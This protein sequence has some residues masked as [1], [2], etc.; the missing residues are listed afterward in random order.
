MNVPTTIRTGLLAGVLVLAA[1]CA[2]T[3]AT[4]PG[5]T[6]A[7]PGASPAQAGGQATPADQQ[8]GAGQG[9]QDPCGLATVEEVSSALGS[10]AVTADADVDGPTAPC[11]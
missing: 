4:S 8:L 9:V 6:S 3:P 2:G 7:S 10:D 11:C 1:A 5:Q